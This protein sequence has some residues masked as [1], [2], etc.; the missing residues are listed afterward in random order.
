MLEYEAL[1]RGIRVLAGQKI[2][3]VARQ[4]ELDA[5]RVRIPMFNTEARSL[6]LSTAA[7]IA[8]YEAL[9]GRTRNS[10]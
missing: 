10:K 9:R 3:D 6:N 5:R 2:A 4:F 8:T 7:G 1:E